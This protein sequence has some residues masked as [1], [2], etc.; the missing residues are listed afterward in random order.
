MSHNLT[1][2]AADDVEVVAKCLEIQV[3]LIVEYSGKTDETI[4]TVLVC[5]YA[6]SRRLTARVTD[7]SRGL[8][9]LV[10]WL[11]TKEGMGMDPTYYRIEVAEPV[12]Y[13]AARE[14]ALKKAKEMGVVVSG[15]VQ[16]FWPAL[17]TL[18]R[19]VDKEKIKEALLEAARQRC[20]TEA[21]VKRGRKW[22]TLGETISGRKIVS[23]RVEIPRE[24]LETLA[25]TNQYG[26]HLAD[27]TQN[28]PQE[29]V[30]ETLSTAILAWVF[31]DIW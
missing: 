30:V 13:K 25:V 31:S 16:S 10:P 2:N 19:K 7:F 4:A 1:A 8:N 22:L 29:K 20:L 5:R 6:K 21:V 12:I 14:A 11:V 28:M 15:L 24:G 27:I 3:P 18:G 9:Y 26:T 23:I 17:C